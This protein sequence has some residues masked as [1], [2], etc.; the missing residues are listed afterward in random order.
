MNLSSITSDNETV[1]FKQQSTQREDLSGDFA[2]SKISIT[3]K[4][5][6]TPTE[7]YQ[8]KYHYVDASNSIEYNP[9]G[10]TEFRKRLQL[11]TLARLVSGKLYQPWVFGYNPLALPSRRSYA[12]DH[13]GFYNGATTNTTLLPAVHADFPVGMAALAGLS[14]TDWGF[15]PPKHPLGANREPDS[16]A[17]QAQILTSVQYPTGGKTVF[18][19]E[20]NKIPLTE[21]VYLDDVLNLAINS[22]DNP[23]SFQKVNTFQNA[24][25]Q[26]VKI[27][28]Q[29][30]FSSN[31]L[32]DLGD[33]TGLCSVSLT[34]QSSTAN[35][36]NLSI[37]KMNLD[38][39]NNFSFTKYLNMQELDYYSFI[40]KVVDNGSGFNPDDFT[41]SASLDFQVDNISPPADKLVGGIRLAKTTLF[42]GLGQKATQRLFQ[43]TDPFVI[44]PISLSEYLENTQEVVCGG[45]APDPTYNIK[46]RTS[47]AKFALGSIQGGTIGYGT[48]TTLTDSLGTNGKTVS[49][50]TN[51]A[52]E[53]TAKS[54]VFPYPS[55]NPKDHRRGLLLSQTDY[56][57]D[58]T[59][60]HQTVNEYVFIPKDSITSVK[61][62]FLTYYGTCGNP[63]L[64]AIS[65]C[66]NV[67]GFCGVAYEIATL[68]TEQVNKTKT[69]ERSYDLT[70]VYA[71]ETTMENFYEN[72]TYTQV[73]RTITTEGKSGKV[74]INSVAK[75]SRTIETTLKYPYDFTTTPYSGMVAKNIIAPVIEKTAK[76]RVLDNVGTPTYTTLSEEK[77]AFS[78]FGTSPNNLYLPQKIETRLYGSLGVWI[79]PVEFLNYDNRGNLTKYYQR[80]GQTTNLTYYGTT[81]YGKTDLV[82]S[83]SVG[84]GLTGTEL[85]RSMNYDY[86]PLVG[87]SMSSDVNAYLTKYAHDDF[88]RLKSVKDNSDYLLKD[89]RYH[90]YNEINP[91][92]IGMNANSEL[93]FVVSRTAREAQTGADLSNSVDVTNTQ[94]QYMDGLGR[95]LQT[96]L[97]RANP[98]KTKD[99]IVSTTA[100]N[101]FGQAYKGILPTPSNEAFGVYKPNAQSLASSFY[102]DTHPYSETIFEP[103]PLN[104]PN[105]VFGAGKNWRVAGNEKF[106]EISYR[107]AGT[108]VIQFNLQADGSIKGDITYP[109]SSLFNNLTISERG[110]WTIELKE[111]QGKVTHKFQQLQA[112]FVFA[113]TAYCYDDLGRLIA[114]IPPEAYKKFGTGE[115]QITS[116]TESDEIFKELM[117]GYHYDKLG[118]QSEKHIAGAGWRYSVF[119]KNDREV[120]F[121]DDAD[122]A[123]GFWQFRKFDALSRNVQTGILN[124]I[125]STSRET[126]QTAFDGIDGQT[127]ETT[128]TGLF[129]YTNVSFPVG[130]VP[131]EADVMEVKYYDDYAWQTESAY[132]F[133]RDYA[134]HDLGLTKGLM[135]GMLSRNLETNEWLKTVNYFDYRGK[136]IQSWFKNHKGNIERSETQ[137][138]FNGEV[139]KMRLDHEVIVEIYDYELDHIGR[140]T[141][142]KHT[143]NGVLKNIS[144]YEHDEIGRL[145][146]KKL[147]PSND[148]G[149][150]ASGEWNNTNVWLNGSVPSINDHVFIN[151]SHVITIPN[152]QAG[153]AGSLFLGGVLNNYG[154][155]KLGI[156]PSNGGAG[157]L[158]TADYSYH[159]RGGLRGINL[160][161]SGNLTNKLFSMKLGYEDAGFWDGNIGKQEWKSS[162]DNITRSFTYDYDGAS[163]IIKGLYASGKAGENYS[164][165]NV[166]Y[167]FSGNVTNL[168]R[169]GFKS[170]N[171]FGLIDN[172]NYTYNS[173]SNKI[174]KVDDSSNETASFK[175]VTGNDYTYSLDGSLTSDANKGITLIEYNYLK[176]PR[177]IVQNG[178]TTLIQYSA[179]GAK[180]KEIIGSDVK[181]YFGNIIKKNG[182]LYQ[183]SHDEGRI[184]N[185][186]YE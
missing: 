106:T 179:S 159:I 5:A 16:V 109:A 125:G 25:P 133:Q 66:D 52:D 143:L 170:N 97:W 182:I 82:S 67:N 20:A 28:F 130:Y 74:S 146:T 117:F 111:P 62:S 75:D 134:F 81:D 104:R 89:F 119:D 7:E 103:S 105:K 166:A 34:H 44:N 184:I 39:S 151:E 8:F 72:A 155:L 71:V 99:I 139:L 10:K 163:R 178:V 9:F 131:T 77:T 22:S 174:L 60:V 51:V 98:D 63:E 93:N 12:Q 185:G 79:T 100:Y 26:Y 47:N 186:E 49:V 124:G 127:Y 172:L 13:F 121:A 144:K 4:N 68:S 157:D 175:D 11:D 169:N 36:F 110:F 164:L 115:G 158:Q 59:K 153:S 32:S 92:G 107:I 96:L 38:A 65:L 40:L 122:K 140:K 177:K 83:I 142:F 45:N 114:V 147:S 94:I 156:L 3:P 19:F 27:T 173:N 80:N 30:H 160:D 24:K 55:T 41:L 149:T 76:L 95:D 154:S 84:G 123:K 150:Q 90:Y 86:K 78:T 29:G 171:T 2:L 113:I 85:S 23:F 141:S 128:G 101:A 21:A 88:N 57:A 118:R 152:G 43:Y 17:M 64:G 176:L 145:K 91:T 54:K 120:M 6:T 87:L 162:L 1:T 37:K 14:T 112:G 136:L 168:S 165:N 48:V 61:A 53:G 18:N 137:Y 56:R 116:F 46:S 33:N 167:D 135:T 58:N 180:L 31:F 138:R 73:S 148:I 132:N 108:E 161:D 183:I 129:G 15:F 35:S 181:D 126:L 70:G 42:D 50:F 102:G 69:L